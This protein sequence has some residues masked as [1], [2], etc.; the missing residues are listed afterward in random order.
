MCMQFAVE[1]SKNTSWSVWTA[2]RQLLA[3]NVQHLFACAGCKQVVSL[4]GPA[5]E[6]CQV[7][8]PWPSTVTMCLWWLHGTKVLLSRAMVGPIKL[9]CFAV[10]EHTLS[11][12]ANLLGSWYARF[13]WM[14]RAVLF[15]T[16]C[17]AGKRAAALTDVLDLAG[18][19]ACDGHIVSPSS[20]SWCFS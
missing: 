18:I 19:A 9:C 7:A 6:T 20:F 12:V 4:L 3:W 17:A 14:S 1:V 13:D 2:S 5:G 16:L 15:L 11:F 10:L 8:C